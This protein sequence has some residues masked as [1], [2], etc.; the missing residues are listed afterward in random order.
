MFKIMEDTSDIRN[1]EESFKRLGLR[2]F[3]RIT[4]PTNLDLYG[5]VITSFFALVGALFVYTAFISKLLPDTGNFVLD[6]FK[7]DYYFCFL[8]PLSILPT[9]AV[10]YLNWLAMRHF[11][12]N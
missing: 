3:G 5:Y 4:I 7:Y 12:Q 8:V 10:I 6:F 1:C 2:H 9:Y 11:E